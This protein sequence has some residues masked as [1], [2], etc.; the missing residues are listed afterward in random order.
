MCDMQKGN[1]MLSFLPV[2]RQSRN[3]YQQLQD[4]LHSSM[5]I[6]LLHV[7][8]PLCWY[9]VIYFKIFTDYMFVGQWFNFTYIYLCLVEISLN[10]I[11]KYFNSSAGKKE[12]FYT[13]ALDWLPHMFDLHIFSVFFARC[14]DLSTIVC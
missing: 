11:I 7:Y 6:V 13:L 4:V 8:M 12:C 3:E 2:M 10:Y 9:E 14:D 5:D 1:D